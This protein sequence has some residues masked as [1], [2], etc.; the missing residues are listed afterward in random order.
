[1]TIFDFESACEGLLNGTK[2]F[3]HATV[4]VPDY[5]KAGDH[6]KPV[7][8]DFGNA[9]QKPG[10]SI[11]MWK[12]EAEAKTWIAG[13]LLT[14]FNEYLGEIE[15]HKTINF[16]SCY[17]HIF[18]KDK[19]LLD[20]DLY[21]ESWWDRVKCKWIIPERSKNSFMKAIEYFDKHPIYGYE[22]QIE[23]RSKYVSIGQTATL[24]EYT[25]R[26][27]ESIIKQIKKVRA[28]KSFFMSSCE[29]VPDKYYDETDAICDASL[30]N[31]GILSFLNTNEYDKNSRYSDTV[32]DIRS[33]FY[34]GK[35]ENDDVNGYLKK[36]KIHL[37]KMYP[38][39]RVMRTLRGRK[40][41]KR[42]YGVG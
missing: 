4:G 27:P 16:E 17:K 38:V 28:N 6:M 26:D 18:P 22:L 35:M 12:S 19:M 42:K 7:S 20:D 41:L 15:E 40:Y 11:F 21:V 39:E 3:W 34:S 8:I 5:I 23:T 13:L 1:M 24:K 29:V 10:K 31:R 9:M 25:T 36:N 33:D 2:T 37:L 30:M 32:G 14:N